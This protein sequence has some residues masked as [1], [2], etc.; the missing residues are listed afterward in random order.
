MRVVVITPPAP[1]VTWAEGEAH[2]RL[3][4]DTDQQG[5]VEAMIAAV[6][7]H[8]D[9][10]MGWLGRS[11]GVQTLEARCDH[12]DCGS[13]VLPYPPA[14][15]IDSVKYVDAGG[16]EQTIDASVYELLGASLMSAYGASWP[17]PR[18]QREAVRV[19]YQAGYAELPAPIRAAILL[20]LGD[21]YAFRETAVTGTISSAVA[22]SPAVE[23]LLAPFRMFA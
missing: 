15:A 1:V 5:E 16:A 7:A 4:G 21:L 13:M 22:M 18:R 14:I 20:M 10:P 8:I 3:D 17:T 12:F 19:R 11:I 2:L 23:R 6:T 9:G